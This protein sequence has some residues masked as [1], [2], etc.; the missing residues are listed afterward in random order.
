M[1]GEAVIDTQSISLFGISR[2]LKDARVAQLA[3]FLI[4]K[5]YAPRLTR[6]SIMFEGAREITNSVD[7]AIGLSSP[8][9]SAML[10]NLTEAGVGRPSKGGL[11]RRIVADT[12]FA[13]TEGN[14]TPILLT[15]DSGIYNKLLRCRD[16][17][18]LEPATLGDRLPNLP[19]F[20][21]GFLVTI[22]GRSIFVIP[23]P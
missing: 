21:D 5:G 4:G 8:E 1:K 16:N 3:K 23:A 13:K 20:R 15:A 14:R 9:Y 7:S 11:D 10:K 19:Q 18:P 2:W 17:E 22:S 12:F 6:T